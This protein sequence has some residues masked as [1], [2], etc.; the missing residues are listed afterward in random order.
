VNVTVNSDTKTIKVSC[1]R[2]TF[3][4]NCLAAGKDPF[5]FSPGALSRTLELDVGISDFLIDTG[6]M[7]T[8]QLFSSAQVTLGGSP[9]PIFDLTISASNGSTPSVSL[10]VHSAAQ[11]Q[12]WNQAALTSSLTAAI[13][14][15]ANPG[16][17]EL[18]NF[19]FP[20][21]TFNLPASTSGVLETLDEVLLAAPPS[22]PAVSE[23][24]A[25]VLVVLLA[26]LGI[27]VLV[28]RRIPVS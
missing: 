26:S 11:G 5:V 17:Y 14:P 1:K 15:T 24:G 2:G 4:G 10:T 23:W 13:T 22:I 9:I 27:M 20:M 19:D 21:L 16:E 3:E 6:L 12:G 25:L 18:T 8:G 28:K 7:E